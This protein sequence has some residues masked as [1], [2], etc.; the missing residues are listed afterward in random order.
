MVV[1]E[2]V[3]RK[4]KENFIHDCLEVKGKKIPKKTIKQLDDEHL[5]KLCA[6]F[7][8]NFETYVN[9]PP[10]KLTKYFADVV[11]KSNNKK[12]T[13]ENRFE[14]M[15]ACKKHLE[16][17]GYEIVKIVPA[18]GHHLCEYCKGIVDGSDKDILCDECI[19]VFGH[20]RY[21]EL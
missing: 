1:A 14:N 5:D 13:I 21:S 11:K 10:V 9:N 7:Q 2:K 16:N 19:D 17:E 8:Q 12:F 18:R 20:F 6:K 3:D 15:D 4:T